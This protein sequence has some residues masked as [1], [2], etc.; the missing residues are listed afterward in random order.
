M[1]GCP[2]GCCKSTAGHIDIAVPRGQTWVIN[3]ELTRTGWEAQARVDADSVIR[4]RRVVLGLARRLNA[5][6]S[7]E[8]LTPAQASV[9]AIVVNRGPLGLAELIEI[10]GLNPTMLS[11]VV[12]SLDSSGLVRRRRDPDD[13]RAARV[14]VTPAG[15]E[16]WQRI[17]AE[18][19]E[20]ISECAACLPAEQE[21]ALTAALPALESLSESLR[22][23][24]RSGRP[25]R[26]KQVNTLMY[27]FW[28][29]RG[30]GQL[31]ARERT[32]QRVTSRSIR[33][34]GSRRRR[35]WP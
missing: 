20:V 7:G 17:S 15:E 11:R 5:A 9:L 28:R 24:L 25:G 23:A 6:S 34:L 30:L 1:P 32:R 35:S 21:A 27:G 13:Y 12:G 2:T 26:D 33:S 29:L 31:P 8:G 10:E 3:G 18:R 4:L 22:A 14:E 19:T 16:V